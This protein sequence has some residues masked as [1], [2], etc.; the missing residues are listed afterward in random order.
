[1]NLTVRWDI[2]SIEALAVKETLRSP[3]APMILAVKKPGYLGES[4]WELRHGSALTLW[5]ASKRW[6]H[7]HLPKKSAEGVAKTRTNRV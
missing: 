3:I 5:L 4:K 1:M 2:E 6:H 7:R